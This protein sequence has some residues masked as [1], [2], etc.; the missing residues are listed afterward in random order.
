MVT[1]ITPPAELIASY[2]PTSGKDQADGYAG[3]DSSTLVLAEELGTGTPSSAVLLR[4]DRAWVT[5]T[6]MGVKVMRKFQYDF[7]IDGGVAGTI[8]LRA[9]DGLG[10]TLPDKF[11]AA[12]AIFDVITAV[13]SAGASTAALT[14][15]QGAGDLVVATVTA[16]AP[17][18]TTG[19]KATLVL[20]GTVSGQIKMTAARTPALVVAIADLDAGKFN[21]FVEGMVSD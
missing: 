14:T 7:S 2:Q 19:L 17:W 13:H 15:G 3:L 8:A 18:S 16:G 6:T 12:N 10:A 5:P 1:Q 9:I 11:I 21:L 4:G 20:I